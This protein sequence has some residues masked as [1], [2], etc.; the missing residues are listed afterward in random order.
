MNLIEDKY[1]LKLYYHYHIYQQFQFL[2]R[3]NSTNSRSRLNTALKINKDIRNGEEWAVTL[4]K[5]I[6][7]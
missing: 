3:Y 5:I 7:I 6:E 2:H 1:L 4:V